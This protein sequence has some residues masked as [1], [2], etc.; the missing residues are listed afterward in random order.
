MNSLYRTLLHHTIE[1]GTKLNRRSTNR[2]TDVSLDDSAILVM[3]DFNDIIPFSIEPDASIS[4]TND[5]MI[6]C[7]VR[8]LFVSDGGGNLLGLVTATDIKGE[9]PVQFMKE[10][11]GKF[12][13]ILCQDIMTPAERLDALQLSDIEKSRVG[14]IVETMKLFRRQHIL[15]T[16]KPD[17]TGNEVIRGIFS[18]SQIGRQLGFHIEPTER[19]NSF[20]E[21]EQAILAG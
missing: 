2:P 11:G 3:T 21:L 19:A 6:A 20:A 12:E 1:N 15:V 16:E 13:D 9:K 18:T 7:G 17:G 8:L 4:A 14:D 10:H 5:K